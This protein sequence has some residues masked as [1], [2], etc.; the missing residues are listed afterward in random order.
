MK[1]IVTFSWPSWSWKTSLAQLL[2]ERLWFDFPI[3]YTTRKPRKSDIEY[4]HVN[5]DDY[6]DLLE[7][8]E[9]IEILHYNNNYYGIKEPHSNKVV[10]AIDVVWLPQVMK[11]ALM[12][13]FSHLSFFIDVPQDIIESRMRTRGELESLILQR[14][15]N[16]MISN[17]IWGK[18][19]DITIDGS[20]TIE[21][22]YEQ[23]LHH[24]TK[25]LLFDNL[26][27]NENRVWSKD[28]GYWLPIHN[29]KAFWVLSSAT[30]C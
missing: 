15:K 7:K 21:D 3:N 27:D 1:T 17:L 2:S 8:N 29:Q 24:L 4:I 26:Y 5:T 23:T 12:N 25:N 9:L 11:Y 6:F 13:N 19:C 20:W 28:I 14:H 22:S 30:E 18:L 16:D 10:M